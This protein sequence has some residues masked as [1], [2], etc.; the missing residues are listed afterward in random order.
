MIWETMKM[1]QKGF[2][3]IMKTVKTMKTFQKYFPETMKTMKTRK[4]I[5]K[6]P[7]LEL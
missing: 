1:Y 7:F 5:P 6:K 3:E 4:M 2:P